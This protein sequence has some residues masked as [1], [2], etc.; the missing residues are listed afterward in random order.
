MPVIPSASEVVVATNIATP[1]APE[2]GS[3]GSNNMA[4]AI[5][6]H[7]A[8]IVSDK[9]D[10]ALKLDEQASTMPC[11]PWPSPMQLLPPPVPSSSG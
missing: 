4:H 8:D 11:P 9:K 3:S 10:A 7:W 2:A 6:E 5:L 1:T